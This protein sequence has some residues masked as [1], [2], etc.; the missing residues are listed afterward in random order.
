MSSDVQDEV[1]LERWEERAAL[2]EH[3]GDQSRPEAEREASRQL[4]E[5]PALPPR[6][7]KLRERLATQAASARAKRKTA[8]KTRTRKPRS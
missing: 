3:H 1:D 8:P 5:R 2:L 6:L 7:A 4:F